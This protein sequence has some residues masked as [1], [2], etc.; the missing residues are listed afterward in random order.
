MCNFHP[1]DPLP[2][3]LKDWYDQV[4]MCLDEDDYDDDV[5]RYAARLKEPILASEINTALRRPSAHKTPGPDNIPYELLEDAFNIDRSLFT[6][7]VNDIWTSSYIPPRASLAVIVLL[8]KRDD[9]TD[10][11][12]YHPLAMLSTYWKL[13]FKLLNTR[14]YALL[15]ADNFLSPVQNG[16]RKQHECLQHVS[17][18]LN[19]CQWRRSKGKTT[20]MAF[21]DFRKAYDSVWLNGLWWKLAKLGVGFSILALLKNAYREQRSM[22]R[23]VQGY[24]DAFPILSGVRQCCVLSPLLFSIYI[25]DLLDH[26]SWRGVISPTHSFL[27]GLLYADDVVLFADSLRDL[28]RAF[29]HISRWCSRWQMTLS[30]T[31]C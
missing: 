6:S 22:V 5:H 9:P 8:L 12:N 31:K 16:F 14:L 29:S 4:D 11:N 10:L 25:N 27:H 30:K 15:D 23:T 17:T 2:T 13:I 21:L 19:T 24:T 1:P 26:P 3:E 18:L 20:W 28:R 7:L